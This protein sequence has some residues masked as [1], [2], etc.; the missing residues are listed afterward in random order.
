MDKKSLRNKVIEI[1]N[2]S[3]ENLGYE[4]VDVEFTKGIKHDLLSIF[5]Y[6]KEG[7]DLDDCTKMSHSIEKDIDS[8]EILKNPYYLEISSPG[9]DRPLKTKDDYRR[10]LENEVDLKLFGPLNGKK[11]YSGILKA[12]D[13]EKITLEVNK[14]NFDIPIKSISSMKQSI[15]F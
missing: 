1:A 10:N 9:L 5:I 14:E 11:E 7:I 4:I 8:L 3:A 12:Y 6:K 2:K 15:K 13:E